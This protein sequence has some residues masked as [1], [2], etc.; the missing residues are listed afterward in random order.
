MLIVAMEIIR[1]IVQ[2][3]AMIPRNVVSM[4]ASPKKQQI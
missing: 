4:M 3:I 2:T 1:K